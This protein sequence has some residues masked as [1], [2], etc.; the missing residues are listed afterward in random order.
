MSGAGLQGL[1]EEIQSG[2]RQ[3]FL[4][5]SLHW[6]AEMTPD[7]RE[8]ALDVLIER[9]T[10]HRDPLAMETL[11]LLGCQRAV[12]S[13]AQLADSDRSMLGSVA[14]RAI[15][16]LR[17]GHGAAEAIGRELEARRGSV[18]GAMH[19]YA[20][21]D[22]SFDDAFE[23]LLSGLDA[24][25]TP[26]RINS[27]NGVVAHLDVDPALLKTHQTPLRVI[28]SRLLTELPSVYQASAV[29]ARDV[30]RGLAQGCSA[31]HLGLEYVAGSAEYVA[32]VWDA[33]RDR[34]GETL[35]A[36][37]IGGMWGHDR[38]WAEA[39]VGFRL[40]TYADARATRTIAAL[41]WRHLVPLLD[42]ALE[43]YWN[44][45]DFCAEA[46]RVRAVLA[47]VSRST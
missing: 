27:W 13:L 26:T 7:C 3:G 42:E 40:G 23:P 41:G 25:F 28:K 2:G 46:R 5:Y 17:P 15:L 9:V 47:G 39:L 8:H 30:F 44:L 32:Q 31:E 29:F 37:A 16:R 10:T 43:K 45:D 36:D 22:A 14:R 11:G 18:Q 24:P 6:F 19:A 1:L 21:R 12:E 34:D 35:G 38:D 33:L 4:A 20:L